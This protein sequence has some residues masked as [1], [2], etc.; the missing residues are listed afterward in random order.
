MIGII[1]TSLANIEKVV[2]RKRGGISE[3]EFCKQKPIQKQSACANAYVQVLWSLRKYVRQN[4]G[5][6]RAL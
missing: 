3:K 4:M 2:F 5:I 6:C 1:G